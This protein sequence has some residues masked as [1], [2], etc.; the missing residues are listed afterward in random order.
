MI[1]TLF[2]FFNTHLFINREL[3][4]K[5][6]IVGRKFTFKGYNNLTLN[7]EEPLLHK[8]ILINAPP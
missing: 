1:F 8:I 7:Y 2:S 5:D 6:N 4:I 3:K